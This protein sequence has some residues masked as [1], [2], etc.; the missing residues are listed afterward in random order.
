MAG[1][2]R[3][4]RLGAGGSQAERVADVLKALRDDAQEPAFCDVVVREDLFG[5]Q[6]FVTAHRRYLRRTAPVCCSTDKDTDTSGT[7]HLTYTY[8]L[9]HPSPGS[10]FLLPAALALALLRR[11]L[12][13]PVQPVKLVEPPAP[14]QHPLRQ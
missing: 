8:S 5:V 12:A 11:P 9:P 4:G 6:R 2:S 1:R 3:S 7:R 10:L 13:A 14:D